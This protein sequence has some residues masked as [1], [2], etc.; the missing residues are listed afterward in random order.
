MTTQAA[1]VR[2]PEGR[3]FLFHGLPFLLLGAPD[4]LTKALFNYKIPIYM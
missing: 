3:L 1:I 4:F 2:I